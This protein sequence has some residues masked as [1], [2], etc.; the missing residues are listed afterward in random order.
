MKSATTFIIVDVAKD[1]KEVFNALLREGVIIRDMKAWGWSSFIRVTVGTR[2]E[3][4]K[5]LEALKRVL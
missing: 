4:V 1:C 2:S 5:F 3:N